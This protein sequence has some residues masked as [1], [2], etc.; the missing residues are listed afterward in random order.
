[1]TGWEPEQTVQ[2]GGGVIYL[3]RIPKP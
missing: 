2:T 3:W 1:M